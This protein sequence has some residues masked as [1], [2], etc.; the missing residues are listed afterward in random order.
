MYFAFSHMEDKY[1]YSVQKMLSLT[2]KV[3][4]TGCKNTNY[5]GRNNVYICTL[6]VIIGMPSLIQYVALLQTFKFS[7]K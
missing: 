6:I 3:V 5:Y 7:Q 2:Q 4:K 1:C